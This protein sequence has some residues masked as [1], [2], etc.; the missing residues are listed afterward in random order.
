MYCAPHKKTTTA[1]NASYKK[2]QTANSTSSS[3]LNSSSSSSS[4]PSDTA[5]IPYSLLIFTHNHQSYP[6]HHLNTHIVA[7]LIKL[8]QSLGE[9]GADPLVPESLNAG[10]MSGHLIAFSDEAI[11]V[12]CHIVLHVPVAAF[13]DLYLG[14]IG[15]G[16]SEIGNTHRVAEVRGVVLDHRKGTG[17]RGLREPMPAKTVCGLA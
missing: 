1:W 14:G 5:T 3:P 2:P 12:V 16:R 7:V 11:A 4:C 13:S 8:E 15:V 17:W 10:V 6:Y 9:S